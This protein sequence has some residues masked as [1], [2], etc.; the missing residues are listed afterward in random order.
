MAQIQTKFLANAAVTNA[1]I[2]NNAVDQN[3]ITS[4]AL[5]SGLAGGSGSTIAVDTTVVRTNGANA[6]TANQSMGGN[7]LTSLADPTVSTD[8][9]TKNY[10][11]ALL[12]G[13]SWKNYARCI[14]TSPLAS[15]TYANGSSGV[16]A[17][18]T[19]T[20]NNSFPAVDGVTLALN[21]RI[22]VAGEST[23]THNGI[24]FL[25]QV[26]SGSVPWILTRSLDADEGAELVA[27]AIFVD[28]GTTNAD[29]AWV[30]TTI[31]PI[32]IA[33]AGSNIVFVKFGTNTLSF[34][35]GL[36]LTGSTVNV[37]PGDTSL[38]ATP[39]SLVVNLNGSGAIV[40]SSG[41]KINLESSNPTLQIS[42]NQLGVKLDGARA[43]TTGASGV[44]VNVDGTSI[45]I[46]GNAV[47][48]K[49]AGVTLA[50]MASNSVDENKI[51]S[52]TFASAGALTGGSGTKVSVNVDA[53]TVKINGSN[54]LESLK[55]FEQ[56]YTV[57]ATDITNQFID[58][59]HAV[60]GTSATLNS[61][62]VTPVGGIMQQKGTDYTVSLTGGSGGVTRVTLAGDL[63]TG[64]NAALVNGDLVIFQY[65]YLT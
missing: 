27:A 13:L 39:A 59:S 10:V 45:D 8:A 41:L 54:N 19:S 55:Q 6:F 20:T 43:I 48:I 56:L 53:A 24:Y 26:G 5:G 52:T 2:A 46:S 31:A 35:N 38:T 51:V 16:G 60:W 9:A 7:K 36:Q 15:N 23:A 3:K 37:V 30:Q 63:A 49:A 14:A 40:T 34:N 47:E 18:L 64:G 33:N 58:L 62:S 25:S 28:E 17:T 11:D 21:D 22:V 44:G 12:N 42:S 32:T 50:K 1:K 29:T 4:S 61:L 65:A 57:T